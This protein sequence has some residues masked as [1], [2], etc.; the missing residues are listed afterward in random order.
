M[1]LSSKA[2]KIAIIG[3]PGSGKTSIIDKLNQEEGYTFSKYYG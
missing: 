1:T 3:S 2:K